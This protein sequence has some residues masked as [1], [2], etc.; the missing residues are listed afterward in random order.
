MA[1]SERARAMKAAGQP[2]LDLASGEPDFITPEPIRTATKRALDEGDTH[3]VSPLGVPALREAIAQKLSRENGIEVSSNQI[4][5][6]AGAKAAL[7][8]ALQALAQPQVE[9]LLPEPAWVSFRPMVELAGGTVKTVTLG[10]G[11][12]LTR[13]A[14]E[15][16]I[17]PLS[18]VL[19]INSPCNPTG[20]VLDDDERAAII[21]T[22]LEHDLI[23]I[24]DEIYERITYP[25]HRHISLA[26]HPLMK[27][28]TVTVNGFSKAFAM[29]GWR[30]GYLSGPDWLVSAAAKIHGHLATCA[31][32]FAQ[33]GALAALQCP[34][35]VVNDLVFAWSRRRARVCEAL[36]RLRGFRCPLPD[37]AFYAFIDIRPTGLSSTQVATALLERHLLA[38]VPGSAFGA[39]GEGFIRLSFAAADETIDR[40]L[41]AIE[42][43]SHTL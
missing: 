30:L 38:V 25:P 37:G 19:I 1:I 4:L 32:S 9:V 12:R 24:A 3:Y 23:V 5:V 11:F 26:A 20:R 31:N 33:A 21:G 35:Q 40:A 15:A 36:D 22:A 41:T 6:T 14:L 7:Y 42:H 43:F 2:V 17:S 34:A 39:A 18:K 13:E 10:E 8:V 28:R 27:Q 29:T 16:S